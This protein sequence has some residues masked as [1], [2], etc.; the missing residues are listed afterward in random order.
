[1]FGIFEVKHLHIFVGTYHKTG[2]VW[3]KRVMRDLAKAIDVPFHENKL[4]D[5][6]S[7]AG[8]PDA[9]IHMDDHCYFPDVDWKI[10]PVGFRM[11]RDP[12]DVVISGAH[13]HTRSE[14]S[15]LHVSREDLGGKSYQQAINAYDDIQDRYLFEM[16]HVGGHTIRCMAQAN[17]FVSALESVRYENLMQDA[18]FSQFRGLVASL[19]LEQREQEAAVKAFRKHSLVGDAKS[20]GKHGTSGGKLGRWK[21]AFSRKTAEIFADRYGEALVSLG[22]E[23]DNSWI[24]YCKD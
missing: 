22:Y 16:N 17:S 20:T 18:D 13:Y 23:Q 8:M 9:G 6:K 3:I 5:Q 19:G 21:T 1:M 24:E 12:R 14:E 10:S 4:R 15:W 2:T 11:I 7:A